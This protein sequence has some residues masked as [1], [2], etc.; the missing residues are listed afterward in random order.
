MS[1]TAKVDLKNG[2]YKIEVIEDLFSITK[3]MY[4]KIGK[5]THF[6]FELTPSSF[7]SYFSNPQRFKDC[8]CFGYFVD[9]KVVSYIIWIKIYDARVNKKIIQ[10]Y[11]WGSD[12]ETKGY[13][14]KLFKKSL[15]YI[16]N[17]YKFDIVLVAN[18][19][20]NSK[21]EKF[22]IRNGFKLESKAFYK[23]N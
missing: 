21:L 18:S 13:G 7:T 20:K 4:A 19:E 3:E 23:V 14:I 16:K 8:F 22:Y 6:G 1:E 5:H 10:E 2:L 12:P 9:G 11:I 15:E 17:I